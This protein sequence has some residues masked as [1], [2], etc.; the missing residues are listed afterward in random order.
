MITDDPLQAVMEIPQIK[1]PTVSADGE[2]IAFF[3]DRNRS[4]SLRILPVERNGLLT[5]DEGPVPLNSL[6]WDDKQ[7][8]YFQRETDT[9]GTEVCR[10]SV[11]GKPESI[12]ELGRNET[13][14]DVHPMGRHLFYELEP[15]SGES[16]VEKI[17]EQ[18]VEY[19]NE[20]G[21]WRYDIAD[22]K[23]T[24]IIGDSLV[25]MGFTG[26]SPDGDRL[27]YTV[28]G[29]S[30][31]EYTVYISDI[32]G[33][34][35][36]AL[37]LPRAPGR[38]ETPIFVKGWHPS[39]E[40]ILV[41]DGPHAGFCGVYDLVDESVSWYGLNE[42]HIDEPDWVPAGREAPVRFLPDG[43]RF[44]IRRFNKT[45]VPAIY[46]LDGTSRELNI[47]GFAGFSRYD[48]LG[49]DE[50]LIPRETET[51]PGDLL[52]YTLSTDAQ[53]VLY[54]VDT[55]DV[56]LDQLAGR[57]SKTYEAVDGTSADLHIWDSGVRPAPVVVELYGANPERIHQFRRRV[58]YLVVKG[59]TVVF[60]AHPGNPFTEEE[61]ANHARAAQ[62][63]REQDWTDE[64]RTIAMGLSH[65]GYDVYMQMV[66]Y[67]EL[68]SAGIAAN[69]MTDLQAM[70]RDELA[71]DVGAREVLG[72][73]DENPDRW[74]AMSP[75][76]HVEDFEGP[77]HIRH[78]AEDVNVPIDQA[79]SFRDALIAAGFKEG[80]DFEYVEFPEFGHTPGHS[81]DAGKRVTF[82]KPVDE[83]L[84]ERFT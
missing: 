21:L 28:P 35:R 23:H 84:A 68:W 18:Y 57:E 75:I 63:V 14:R 4:Y 41:N 16:R 9:G 7:M 81:D 31:S 78:G 67:P 49:E 19:R 54:S 15:E 43:S 55:G 38:E 32:D 69:G 11:G 66:R 6:F 64:N 1:H 20:G 62:W 71:G 5:V 83:F 33:D 36:S 80:D 26:C 37:E 73:P 22:G 30:P 39:G 13:L 10:I 79:R 50:L 56:S 24:Q 12:V 27:A 34:N 60:P 72:E 42:D 82:W 76:T 52:G 45:P 29:E 58:Q 51:R 8:L 70:A 65:G 3:V 61:H 53:R 77:L 46:D 40:K 25:K 17:Q 2:Y 47:E 48:V 74:E 59:F 44:L